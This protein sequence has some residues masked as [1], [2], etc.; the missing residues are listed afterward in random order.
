MARYL[1]VAHRTAQ[2]QELQSALL[3]LARDDKDASFVLLVP[4]SA[5]GSGLIQD[6]AGAEATARA[7]ADEAQSRLRDAR[8]NV[9]RAIVGPADPVKGIGLELS[10]P[11]REYAAIVV[12]TL[13]VG[14][15]AWLGLDVPRR[16]RRKFNRPVTHVVCASAA[17]TAPAPQ[18]EHRLVPQQWDLRSLGGFRG[19][20]VVSADGFRLG[21]LTNIVYDYVS[22]DP[23]WLGIG[24]GIRTFL[25]P[26]FAASEE[27]DH[28]RVGYSK[29]RIAGEPPVDI[30]E[31]FDSLTDEHNLYNYFGI[32]FDELRDVRVLHGGDEYPGLIRVT[33]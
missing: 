24:S 10:R 5:R 8:I 14:A 12:S 19:K 25:A 27:N 31:G 16:V 21:I 11:G 29:A 3:H 9:E 20:P 32:P 15:S 6:E 33:Q 4:A 18:D 23:V 17:A 1:V 26:A 7:A 2:S 22:Q 13:P 28:H 30:G